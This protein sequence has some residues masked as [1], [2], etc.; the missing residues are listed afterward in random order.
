MRT[1]VPSLPG[2]IVDY[3]FEHRRAADEERRTFLTTPSGDVSFRDL[4]ARTCQ[5]GGFLKRLGVKTGERVMLCVLDGPDFA[6]I[7]LG[8]MKI[9]AVSLPLNTFLKSKDY[10]YY[11]KDSGAKVVIADKGL[12]PMIGEIIRELNLDIK[13]FVAGGTVPGVDSLDDAIRELP[14]TLATEPRLPDDTAF[15]LYS[16]GSTG[17][18]KG[19]VHTHAHIYWATELFGIGTLGITSDDVILCPPKMFFAYGL[20]FQNYMPLRTGARILAEGHPA[21]P[22]TILAKLIEHEP[23]MLVAVPTIFVSL[24]EL[25]R[26]MDREQV[27][28]AC[29]RLRVCVSGGEVL[30]PSVLNAWRELTGVDIL[31]GVGTSEMTHMFMINRPGKVIPGSC[32]QLVEGYTARLV[33]DDWNDVPR[34]EI[35]NLFVIGPTAAREYWNK[36][37]KT[38]ATMRDGGVLTGDKFYQDAN[39]NYIY[40]GRYDDMLRVGGIWVSPSEIESALAEH[41]AVLECAVIGTADENQLIK[42]KAF[43]VLRPG[44]TAE[45]ELTECISSTMR[46]KLAH[47]KCPRWI[48][49]VPEL[50]KTATGKIQ[51][52]KLRQAQV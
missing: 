47:H 24:I 34:G 9:G 21:R 38:A 48:E 5:V 25:M 46:A 1:D 40:V 6:A 22:D 49:F 16:S 2:N 20:G 51:R 28:R 37:E 18:P 7:F 10:A 31:D 33:D 41:K 4:Y 27:R 26:K 3:L 15:W 12:A 42:P 23:T 13:L 30:A 50:P 8:A 35:G 19:V 14:Q 11:I 32:G 29:H 17:D 43:I 36:P 39:G 52:F 45:A 44:F